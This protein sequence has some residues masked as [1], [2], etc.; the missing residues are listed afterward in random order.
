MRG[1][2][3]VNVGRI[4]WLDGGAA[5]M[6]GSESPGTGIGRTAASIRREDAVRLTAPLPR[7]SPSR[8][9]AALQSQKVVTDHLKSK[10]Y[11]ASWI[12]TK[13][14][15]CSAK[16]RDSNCL[17]EE[18]AATAFCLWKKPQVT[19]LTQILILHKS[20]EAYQYGG[21]AVSG[22]FSFDMMLSWN[23]WSNMK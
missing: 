16:S 18:W 17:L 22:F 3:P 7:R 19:L 23:V 20:Y 13:A 14:P 1:S 9:R 5:G 21:R 15:Y 10:L 12:Y 8:H 2:G 11:T 6:A 4:G